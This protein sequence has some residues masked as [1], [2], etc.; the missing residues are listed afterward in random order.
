VLACLAAVSGMILDSATYTDKM[1][2]HENTLS[3]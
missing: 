1:I 3:P 2:E